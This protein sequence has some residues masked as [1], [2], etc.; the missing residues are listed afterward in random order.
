MVSPEAAHLATRAIG[1]PQGE[2]VVVEQK[3]AMRMAG[4]CPPAAGAEAVEGVGAEAHKEAAE[5]MVEAEAKAKAEE[6]GGEAGRGEAGGGAHA[7]MARNI[8]TTV[9]IVGIAAAAAAAAAAAVA[10]RGDW[11]RP[12]R[13]MYA[14][15][16]QLQ[17]PAQGR[18]PHRNQGLPAHLHRR[19]PT[20]MTRLPH[21]RRL[22]KL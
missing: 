14:A 17:L 20:R 1:L 6:M 8:G 7:A 10:V 19:T 9:E 2:K 16:W 12:R 15:R 3:V 5:A 21:L 4:G 18:G 22:P 11:I 13:R